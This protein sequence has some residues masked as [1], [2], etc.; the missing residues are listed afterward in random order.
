MLQ[1]LEEFLDESRS[2]DPLSYG[3]PVY[4]N[5]CDRSLIIFDVYFI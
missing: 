4:D 2:S 3:Y 5:L 1:S